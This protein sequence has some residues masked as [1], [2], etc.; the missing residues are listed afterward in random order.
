MG[1]P[2]ASGNFPRAFSDSQTVL[3]S[4]RV[5]RAGIGSIRRFHGHL[6]GD[7]LNAE[8]FFRLHDAREKLEACR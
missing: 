5:S 4:D 7:S 2:A 3:V 1:K 8:F 6:K